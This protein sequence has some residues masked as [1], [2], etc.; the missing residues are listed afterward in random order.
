MFSI[1]GEF[2]RSLYFFLVLFFSRKV[3]DFSLSMF[4]CMSF[5]F[6]FSLEHWRFAEVGSRKLAVKGSGWL[7]N[8]LRVTCMKNLCPRLLALRYLL[9]FVLSLYGFFGDF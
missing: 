3:Y 4:L 9:F 6:F 1:W 2:R 7:A 8:G 5:S